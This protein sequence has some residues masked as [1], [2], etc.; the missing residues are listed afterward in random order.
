[1]QNVKNPF[2]S[3]YM[4]IISGALVG[5]SPSLY[6]LI[7]DLKISALAVAVATFFLPLLD[8]VVWLYSFENAKWANGQKVAGKRKWR[9]WFFGIAL[10][11]FIFAFGDAFQFIF[12]GNI[13]GIQV[14]GA[15]PWLTI[16]GIPFFSILLSFAT[17]A[18]FTVLERFLD[19]KEK[20]DIDFP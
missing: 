12:F 2:N 14:H 10:G 17:G 4:L 3:R 15:F 13:N 5:I 16:E 11:S 7:I 8:C 9:L 6:F 18:L 1:M 20:G 19:L